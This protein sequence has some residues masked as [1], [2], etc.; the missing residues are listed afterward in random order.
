MTSEFGDS[1]NVEVPYSPVR[2]VAGFWR[3]VVAFVI[4][5]FV[6]C[7]PCLFVSFLFSDFFHYHQRTAILV[8]LLIVI[9]YFA[10]LGS[11]RAGGQTFGMRVMSIEVVD[12]DGRKLALARSFARYMILLIPMMATAKLLP[13]GTPSWLSDG[14]DWIFSALGSVILYLIVF[15]PATRQSL[16]D[17]CTGAFVT[18]KS[19][20]GSVVTR[21]IWTGHWKVLAGLLVVGLITGPVIEKFVLT[22]SVTLGQIMQTLHA[23]QRVPNVEQASVFAQKNWTNNQTTSGVRVVIRYHE[24]PEDLERSAVDIADVVLKTDPEASRGDYITVVSDEGFRVGF[25]TLSNNN[26]VSH[27]PEEWKELIGKP[28]ITPDRT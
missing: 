1:L 15:N 16:H 27:T 3:R 20:E 10:L 4:D 21:P 18:D 22:K 2:S 19:T 8:G 25:F 11:D 12:R 28:A 26:S 24:R 14:I 9:P 7:V 13:F 5:V 23:V 17:L 6:L